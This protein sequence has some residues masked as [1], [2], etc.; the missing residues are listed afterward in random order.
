MCE[1]LENAFL[2]CKR[3]SDDLFKLGMLYFVEFVILGKAQNVKINEEY[4]HLVHNMNEFNNYLWGSI[5]FEHMQYSLFFTLRKKESDE[6][7]GGKWKGQRNGKHEVKRPVKRE[8]KDDR[9]G[10]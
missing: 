8:R 3:G 6:N 1:D 5:L 2:T 4:L 7:D 9:D 10:V